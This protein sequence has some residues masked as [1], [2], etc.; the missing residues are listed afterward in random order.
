MSELLTGVIGIHANFIVDIKIRQQKRNEKLLDSGPCKA[1]EFRTGRRGL[2]G[3][4]I[5]STCVTTTITIITTTTIIIIIIITTIVV[6]VVVAVVNIV[7]SDV[8]ASASVLV[9]SAI[10]L[11]ESRELLQILVVRRL[12]IRQHWRVVMPTASRVD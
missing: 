3:G 5:S 12:A 4:E 1:L 10:R 2:A 7:V 9:G 11:I 6:V 8:R